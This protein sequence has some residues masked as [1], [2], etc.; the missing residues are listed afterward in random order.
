MSSTY[1]ASVLC[2]TRV[3]DIVPGRNGSISFLHTA[4]LTV[5]DGSVCSNKREQK[6]KDSGIEK[7][8]RA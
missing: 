2:I 1:L 7:Y 4:N 8:A 3:R 5:V 6:T